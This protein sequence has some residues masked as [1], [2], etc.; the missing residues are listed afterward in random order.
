M[1]AIQILPIIYTVS[2]SPHSL[3]TGSKN[4]ILQGWDK[5]AH[6]PAGYLNKTAQYKTGKKNYWHIMKKFQT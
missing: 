2:Q 4:S 5:C 6:V 3:Q 1:K